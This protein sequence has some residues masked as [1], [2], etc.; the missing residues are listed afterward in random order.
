MTDAPFTADELERYAR[1][2]VLPEIGGP[3]QQKLKSARVLIAGAGGLGAPVAAYLAAAGVGTLG[4]VDDD[5][6]TLS[7][8]Q[9]QIIHDTD[10]I[11]SLKVD[12]AARSLARINPTVKIEGHALRLNAETAPD[13]I[14]SYDLVS[15]GTDN[16]ATRY[17]LADTCAAL[18]VPLVTAAVGRFYGS[19][20]TLVPFR[21]EAPSYRDLH[22]SPPAEGTLP[23]C[24]EAGILGALTGVIGSLQALEIIKVIAGIGTP[25]IGRL[26]LYDALEQR[27]DIIRYR[28]ACS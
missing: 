16:F 17:L 7:N 15:D 25:L 3:G 2:L 18:R 21:D 14:S 8:L 6:V 1:H 11:G 22:P 4:I 27:F 10:A 24:A 12:S 19:V 23:T 28:R 20:T 5:V 13:L 9:R 26:L